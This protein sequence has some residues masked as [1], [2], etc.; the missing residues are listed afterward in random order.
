M[1][2]TFQYGNVSCSYCCLINYPR[3]SA[4]K[5]QF[6]LPH[7]SMRQEFRACGQLCS[8]QCRLRHSFDSILL[9][10]SGKFKKALLTCL[11]IWYSPICGLCPLGLRL[12]C[13]SVVPVHMVFFHGCWLPRG[14]IPNIEGRSPDSRGREKTP[15][16]DGKQQCHSG[17]EHVGR[18]L[19]W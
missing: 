15:F 2:L 18:T 3:C 7:N 19:M 10:E 5:Q 16:L 4:F 14:R 9:M 17:K 11:E 12:P 6:F 1:E 8:T 13:S